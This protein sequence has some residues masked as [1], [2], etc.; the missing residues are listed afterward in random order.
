MGIELE[1]PRTEINAEMYDER[2]DLVLSVTGSYYAAKCNHCGWV[3]SSEF[4]IENDD[5]EVLCPVCHRHISDDDPV[6]E[7][8]SKFLNKESVKIV[9]RKNAI[10]AQ[11]REALCIV[12]RYPMLPIEL[13][14]IVSAALEAAKEGE[15]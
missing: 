9:Q 12:F 5:F 15:K 8:I 3:G 14:E 7:D 1:T 10:V 11:M 2:V 6:A 13:D 4:C